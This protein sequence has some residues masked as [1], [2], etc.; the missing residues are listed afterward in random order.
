MTSSIPS[1]AGA[2][3]SVLGTRFLELIASLF[4]SEGFQV[5]SD[6]HSHHAQVDL[7]LRSPT[8][9][10]AVLEAKLYRSRAIPTDA[11]YSAAINLE[12]ARNQLNASHSILAVGSRVTEL[13][14]NQLAVFPN[15][16][17]YDYDKL[18]FLASKH[19]ALSVAF[20]RLLRETFAFTHPPVPKRASADPFEE[21]QRP[22]SGSQ[23]VPSRDDE[24]ARLSEE[25]LEVKKGR[26]NAREFED[27]V[28]R[29]LKYIF[30]DDLSGWSEQKVTEH[31]LSRYDLIAKIV[32]EHDFWR[33]MITFFRTGY[34]VF[35]FKNYNEKIKQGQIYTTEKY[36]F[37]P[38]MRNTAIIISWNGADKNAERAARGSLRE[39]GKLIINLTVPD[40]C[41][42][43][44]LKAS[45]D[46][47]NSIIADKVDTIMM[48]LE[49]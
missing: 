14:R 33:S 39:S 31:G 1:R 10:A 22:I 17:L 5:I 6:R 41:K 47:P 29:V 21:L 42:M 19:P 44:Q 18:F 23:P 2:D 49:R 24:S 40:I 25:L 37:A 34:V 30:N 20:D 9:I 3:D 7:L 4:R 26:T 8:G 38:A 32:S 45:G 48:T 11:V 36:L 13:A 27:K 28:G 46:D 35:E 43:V 12:V 16:I 15:L